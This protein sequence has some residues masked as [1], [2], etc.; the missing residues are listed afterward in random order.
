LITI[1]DVTATL[2][3]A[4][5]IAPAGH[6]T[7]AAVRPGDRTSVKALARKDERS[8]VADHVR[9]R[10]IWLFVALHAGAAFLALWRPALRASIAC[11]L[12]S[13]I[14]A[15]FLMMLVP[16]WGWG[17]TGAVLACIAPAAVLAFALTKV[18]HGDV[19]LLVG[20]A[21]A[22]G[23][24]VIAID[25]VLG[26]R[27]EI[28][29]PFGNSPIGGGRF[30]GVGNIPYAFLVATLLVG[31]ALALERWGRPAAPWV[32][33]AFG[34]A[35]VV[36]GAPWFGADA[37]GVVAAA[38][39][40]AGLMV[41]YKRGRPSLRTLAPIFLAG[42]AVVGLFA[43]I[44]TMRASTNQTHLTHALRGSGL[45]DTAARKADRAIATVKTPLANIIVVGAAVLIAAR[46]R[47][48]APA[49]KAA[50][51]ALAIVAVAGSA[52]N[53]SGLQI[54]AAVSAVSW[55]VY[56]AVSPGP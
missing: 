10:F 5:G 15:S 26:G 23:T 41:G 50:A 9:T 43:V 36:D 52:L 51:W 37:G 19:G 53:D 40:F 2:L 22:I 47:L 56:L 29:A 6:L 16:W 8:S 24:T 39:A 54:A 42:I 27:L 21:A 38:P 7:G 13:L 1:S 48:D 31:G 17:V 32:A 35:L 3:S 12:L 14:P 45:G 25:A 46:P 18:S 11:S 49:L 55:P 34:A 28:D 30:Y 20:V 44:D 33:T 4:T